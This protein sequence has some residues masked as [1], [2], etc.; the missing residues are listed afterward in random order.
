MQVTA[1]ILQRAYITIKP[2][3]EVTVDAET[4]KA[5]NGARVFT[6]KTRNEALQLLV[7]T[8]QRN[9]ISGNIK[10]VEHVTE[11]ENPKEKAFKEYKA[12]GGKLSFNE[13][14]NG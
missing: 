1:K 14:Y 5:L 10:I 8:L 7:N 9:S 12:N 6:G 4:Q 2:A 3:F 11:T 13:Y